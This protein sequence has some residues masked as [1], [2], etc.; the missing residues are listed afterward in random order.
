MLRNPRIVGFSACS[1]FYSS[2]SQSGNFQVA[3]MKPNYYFFFLKVY[4]VKVTFC[5]VQF[6]GF[7]EYL[8]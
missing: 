5:G 3:L 6:Y 4:V 2:L 7:D 1:D 8:I